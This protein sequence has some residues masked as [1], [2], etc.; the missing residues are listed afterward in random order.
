MLKVTF[1]IAQEDCVCD[2][3]GLSID[4]STLLATITQEEQYLNDIEIGLC[5]KCIGKLHKDVYDN[6]KKYNS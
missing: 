1:L 3:C 6:Y 4:E 2:S 5:E